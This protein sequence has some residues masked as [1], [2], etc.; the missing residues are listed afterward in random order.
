MHFI[1]LFCFVEFHYFE[2]FFCGLFEFSLRFD[3]LQRLFQIFNI[4][5][6][7][8]RRQKIDSNNDITQ[9]KIAQESLQYIFQ[10]FASSNEFPRHTRTKCSLN[11]ES[12]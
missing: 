8:K 9:S 7:T 2:C 6:N 3:K 12:P 1:L 5:L 11:V 10:V 4:P